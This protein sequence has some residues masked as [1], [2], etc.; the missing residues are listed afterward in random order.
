[1][2][3]VGST[4]SPDTRAALERSTSATARARY[5]TL[6]A[7]Y[8]QGTGR[9]FETLPDLPAD[10]YLDGDHANE[11]GARTLAFWLVR[12]QP[13]LRTL[14]APRQAKSPGE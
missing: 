5:K 2:L 11:S 7:A 13:W 9:V 3:L 8:V 10:A 14:G 4:L 6:L 1:V 12:R